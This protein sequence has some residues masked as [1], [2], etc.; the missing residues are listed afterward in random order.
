MRSPQERNPYYSKL[1][2]DFEAAF[3]NSP[4]TANPTPHLHDQYEILLCLSDDMFCKVNDSQHTVGTNTLMLFNN[5]D[6][7]HF[8][9][10]KT[11]TDNR[12]YVLN[13]K[14]EYL[15]NTITSQTDL[16]SCFLFR[17]FD[18]GHI[19]PLTKQQSS[20]L[21]RQFEKILSHLQADSDECY[22]NDLYVHLLLA[23]V[24]LTI[25]GVYR[26]H[27]HISNT[28]QGVKQRVI[29]EI[30]D[31]VHDNY[32]NRIS[33][34]FLAKEFYINKYN[35][36]KAFRE[37]TGVTFNQYLINW[38]ITKAKQ[39]LLNGKSVDWACAESGFNDLSH[40]S[41][42][43]KNKI[44]LSPKQFQQAHKSK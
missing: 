28:D 31:Y 34:D 7:H 19:L 18:G 29:Y 13:F 16:Y 8:G 14:P 40:F 44:G 3:K 30:I 22:D 39:F 1:N 27:Y 36:C 15:D 4:G 24:L 38:R 35:L 9:T 41:R 43:F 10:V 5:M 12:R 26:K 6:L 23:E 37:V 32:S 25:N 20:E 2:N 42:T 11:K 33:L 21:Q 17:P